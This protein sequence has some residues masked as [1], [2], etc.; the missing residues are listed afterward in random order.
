[1]LAFVNHGGQDGGAQRVNIAALRAWIG[2]RHNPNGKY[3]LIVRDAYPLAEAFLRP[4]LDFRK[5]REQ[6]NCKLLSNR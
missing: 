3:R 6:I 5:W 4:G 1:V 2:F